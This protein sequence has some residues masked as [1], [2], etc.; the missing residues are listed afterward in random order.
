L[1]RTTG[2]GASYEI[3]KYR[4]GQPL[5]DGGPV[6]VPDKAYFVLGDNRDNSVDSRFGAPAGGNSS[7]W[8]VPDTDI[9]GRANYIYWSGF[10]RLGRMG[11]A[12]K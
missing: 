5:D 1:A 6:T 9:I 3:L 12:L 2:H 4:G 11:M 10:E 7:W 8:F